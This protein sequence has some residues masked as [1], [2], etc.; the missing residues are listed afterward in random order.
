[1]EGNY[2]MGP[3]GAAV[4]VEATAY[5]LLVYVHL[6]ELEKALPLVRWL[7]RQRNHLGGFF[8]T[9]V[10]FFRPA[11][12]PRRNALLV[13]DISVYVLYCILRLKKKQKKN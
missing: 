9:R 3:A 11:L 13:T 12:G 2:Y 8:T 1:M 4:N 5:A 7:L 6:G 10:R